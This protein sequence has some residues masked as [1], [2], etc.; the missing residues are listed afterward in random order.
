[1][2]GTLPRPSLKPLNLNGEGPKEAQ[3]IKVKIRILRDHERGLKHTLEEPIWV[4]E[5]PLVGAAEE[6]LREE[7]ELNLLQ[8]AK[9][10]GELTISLGW[11]QKKKR[12]RQK[13]T[14]SSCIRM[15]LVLTRI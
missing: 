4:E 11:S 15:E 1:M 6:E 9:R 7:E 14:Q 10:I 2:F 13:H 3:E 8:E 5:F 12:K